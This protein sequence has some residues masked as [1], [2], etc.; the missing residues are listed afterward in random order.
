MEA[1]VAEQSSFPDI[2]EQFLALSYWNLEEEMKQRGEEGKEGR[3]VDIK[4]ILD[5]SYATCIFCK[6]FSGKV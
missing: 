6:Y 4:G 2:K 3:L 5:V 1:L